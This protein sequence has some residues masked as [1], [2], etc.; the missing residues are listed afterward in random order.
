MLYILR[1]GVVEQKNEYE[2]CEVMWKIPQVGHWL[3]ER[4][5]FFGRGPAF[6]LL[7]IDEVDALSIYSSKKA[8]SN[9][10]LFSFR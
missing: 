1:V 4:V 9:L 10:R 2:L 3:P 6:D 7:S 8:V 5:M